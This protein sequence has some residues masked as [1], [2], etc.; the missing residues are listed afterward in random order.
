LEKEALL[1]FVATP[2]ARIIADPGSKLPGRGVWITCSR[3][4][5]DT[6]AR[7]GIF[8]RSLKRKVH[9]PADLGAEVDTMLLARARNALSLAN[10]AGLVTTGFTKV[11][12]A[13]EKAALTAVVHATDAADDGVRKLDRVV[14]VLVR[15]A[16]LEAVVIRILNIDEMSLALGRSNVVHAAVRCGGAASAFVAAALRLER[17]RSGSPD[18]SREH[19][20]REVGGKV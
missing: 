5:V 15:E 17:Y 16:R 9:A 4:A 10:K 20:R 3:E 18:L 11:E 13:I 6:A 1:R 2:E 12:Q 8:A 19:E 14:A 7:K